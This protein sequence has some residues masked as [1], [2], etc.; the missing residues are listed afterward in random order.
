[1]FAYKISNEKKSNF[2]FFKLVLEA[3]LIL[4]ITGNN[5]KCLTVNLGYCASGDFGHL[6]Y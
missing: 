1:M 5:D 4:E 3:E 2:K 6:T